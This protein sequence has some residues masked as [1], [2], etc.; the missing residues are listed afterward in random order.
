MRRALFKKPCF[1]VWLFLLVFAVVFF[2]AQAYEPDPTHSSLARK[3]AEIYGQL[4]R[5]LSSEEINLIAEGARNEDTPPRWINHFYDPTTGLGWQGERLG[6]VSPAMVRLLSEIGLS[7]ESAV[8]ALDWLH[9]QGLQSQYARYEGNRTFEKAVY[10]YV[11]GDKKEALKSLGH[12][13][14]LIEDMSVPAHTRQDTHVDGLAGDPGEPYEKWA[15]E[16]TD[17][18]HINNLNLRQENFY[19]SNL[20]DCFVKVARYSNEN[21]FSANSINDVAYKR[22]IADRKEIVG[23]FEEYYRIDSKG[24]EYIMAEKDMRSGEI[25]VSQKVVLSSYWRLLSKQAVLAGTEV[26]RIFHEEVAKA[27]KDRNLLKP[28]PNVSNGMLKFTTGLT[29]ILS[30]RELTPLFSPYGEFIK[31]W[32]GIQDIF[33]Q[34]SSAWGTTYNGVSGLFASLFFSTQTQVSQGDTGQVAKPSVV[35]SPP[36][37]TSAQTSKNLVLGTAAPQK[38]IMPAN[39][40]QTDSSGNLPQ[41]PQITE[42][43]FAP[44]TP[45]ISEQIFKLN[46]PKAT[47]SPLHERAIF[48][49]SSSSD[50]I[51]DEQSGTQDESE[52]PDENSSSPPEISIW[53]S[54]YKN[55]ARSFDVNWHSSSTDVA[56]YSVQYKIGSSSAIVWQDWEIATTSESKIFEGSQDL[57]IYYFRARATNASS[58]AGEWQEVAASINFYPVVINEIAWAGTSASTSADEWIELYNKTDGTIDLTGWQIAEVVGAT[59]TVA[60]LQ[61]TIAPRSYYLI[62]RGDDGT[63]S[64]IVADLA[65]SFGGSGLSNSGENLRLIDNTGGIIDW[66][67]FSIGWP[68]GTAG[69]HYLS[70]ERVNP[71]LAWD[72][73]G[74]WKSNSTSTRS[75]INADGRAINGTPKSQNSVFNLEFFYLYPVKETTA[76]STLLEWT[77]SALPGLEKYKV[78]RSYDNSFA[79]TSVTDN[80]SATNFRD[81]TLES[82]TDYYYRIAACDNLDYCVFSNVASTTSVIFP[83]SLAEPEII[84]GNATTTTSVLPGIVLNSESRPSVIWHFAYTTENTFIAVSNKNSGGSWGEIENIGSEFG[85]WSYPPQIF[86]RENNVSV[87]FD[88]EVKPRPWGSPPGFDVF[89][90]RYNAGVWEAVQNVSGDGRNNFSPSGV[91]DQTG[92]THIIWQG[93][94]ST[95]SYVS[96][97]LY[98]KLGADGSFA[99][100]IEKII[101]SDYGVTPNIVLDGN[102]KLHAVWYRCQS[103]ACDGIYYAFNNQDGFG[104]SEARKIFNFSEVWSLGEKPEMIFN[105]EGKLLIS[106]EWRVREIRMIEFDGIATST[107]QVFS[108]GD[109]AEILSLP[110]LILNS[111]GKPYLIFCANNGVNYEMYMVLQREGGRWRQPRKILEFPFYVR[112][113]RGVID[114]QNILRLVFYGGAQNYQVYYTSGQVE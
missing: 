105:K 36:A 7:A 57:T 59:T 60:N 47:S 108:L 69:P 41:Q 14:H 46:L 76:T 23:I 70:M 79:T 34:I 8:S 91:I 67:D 33:G 85:P 80:I 38:P 27:E 6:S 103:G 84:S 37:A 104:W 21:F 39:V 49:R 15:K 44:E 74:N 68:A 22:I 31:I 51:G 32:P 1:C 90:S 102:G 43:V 109:P 93:T 40:I 88:G 53:L 110:E 9:N 86:I 113:A 24:E 26:I 17:L 112:W 55:A 54:D 50:E 35:S 61:N 10:D 114:A 12:I 98:R 96:A 95:T 48:H 72:V 111:S 20:D 19:C 101:D 66:A 16:N 25:L 77:A 106:W 4:G 5:P 75:G 92:S 3:S 29:A 11:N 63:V 78:I 28:P 87:I 52:E 13:L 99:E 71:Y 83:I 42:E 62:E 100:A 56:S 18:S 82:E 64:D 73:P 97:I 2:Y 107:V 94:V 30:A 89:Y 58:S 45:Q 65:H 81:T